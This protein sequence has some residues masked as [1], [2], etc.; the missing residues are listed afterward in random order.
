MVNLVKI[1]LFETYL[2]WSPRPPPPPPRNILVYVCFLFEKHAFICCRRTRARTILTCSSLANLLSPCCSIHQHITSLKHGLLPYGQYGHD[3]AVD[4]CRDTFNV[5]TQQSLR[6]FCFVT[7]LCLCS[8]TCLSIGSWSSGTATNIIHSRAQSRRCN[9][10]SRGALQT[11]HLPNVLR[12]PATKRYRSKV[13]LRNISH[14]MIM[15]WTFPGGWWG[16]QAVRIG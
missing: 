3:F 5:Q 4:N 12:H 14:L 7:I 9:D 15:F 13:K 6:N 16:S 1:C 8:H 10:R 2:Y 11:W